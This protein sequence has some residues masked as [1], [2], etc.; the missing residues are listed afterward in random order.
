MIKAISQSFIKTMRAYNAKEECGHLVRHQFVD[1]QLLP[2]SASMAEG[3]YFEYVATGNLPKSGE[4]PQPKMMKNGKEMLEPYRR[5]EHAAITLKNKFALLGITFVKVGKT[6][7][8]GRY[9]GDL[10]LIIETTQ[11]V[12]FPNGVVWPKGYRCILDLKYSGLLDDRWSKHGW[13]WTN[14]QKEYHGTQATQYHMITGMDFYFLVVSSKNTAVENSEGIKSYPVPAMKLFKVP[15]T[16]EM[17]NKHVQEGNNLFDQFKVQ[18]E[19]GFVARPSMNRCSDCPLWEGCK[20]KVDFPH[21]E[22]VDLTL[23]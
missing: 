15:V 13:A 6:Y 11:E 5:A 22:E 7:T 10:D 3:S 16:D 12:K 1:D 23:R 8:K 14:E 19:L 17:M 21:P 4:I 9:R 2:G 18:A 20:D